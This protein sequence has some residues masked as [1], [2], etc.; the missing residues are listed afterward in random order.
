MKLGFNTFLSACP[1][2]PLHEDPYMNVFATHLCHSKIIVFRLGKWVEGWYKDELNWREP[3]LRK[4]QL[5]GFPHQCM[6][7]KI[8]DV[9][10]PPSMFVWFPPSMYVEENTPCMVSFLNVSSRKYPMYGSLLECIRYDLQ[11]GA[12]VSMQISQSLFLQEMNFQRFKDLTEYLRKARDKHFHLFI[13][14]SFVLALKCA[15]DPFL[16]G[17]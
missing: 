7:K 17:Y 4:Y 13:L 12:A 5:Y 10:F 14:R 15:W 11:D 8:P 2:Y 16:H 6:L 9:R 1:L 3:P